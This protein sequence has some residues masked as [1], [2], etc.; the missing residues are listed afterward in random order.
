MILV[1]RRLH[2]LPKMR[3]FDIR[4]KIETAA[5]ADVA[6][7]ISIADLDFSG[8]PWRPPQPSPGDFVLID[9]LDG[10]QRS[11]LAAIAR[12]TPLMVDAPAS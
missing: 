12:E 5:I 10:G 1:Y 6:E 2:P 11:D 9:S 4:R 7:E 3:D 8:K